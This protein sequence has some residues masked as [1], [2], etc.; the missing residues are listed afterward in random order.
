MSVGR[1]GLDNGGVGEHGI[2]D[3]LADRS[4]KEHVMYGGPS[5]PELH[6]PIRS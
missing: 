1:L 6:P 2:I 3:V 5:E 4:W